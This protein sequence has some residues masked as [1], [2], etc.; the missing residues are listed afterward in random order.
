M[1]SAGAARAPAAACNPSART[2]VSGAPD[3]LS[4]WLSS[5]GERGRSGGTDR[6]DQPRCSDR[7]RCSERRRTRCC[8][9]R[10]DLRQRTGRGAAAAAAAPGQAAHLLCGLPRRQAVL[11]CRGLARA[12]RVCGRARRRRRQ[13]PLVRDERARRSRRARRSQRL[14]AVDQ[15][16]QRPR[17]E[18][19]RRVRKAARGPRGDGSNKDSK[20]SARR[21]SGSSV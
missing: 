18:D 21:S 19:A 11:R 6:G 8:V 14:R 13:L 5:Q 15:G 1:G 16:D 20:E 4:R 3:D 10:P 9:R 2:R 7:V 17:R 12:R